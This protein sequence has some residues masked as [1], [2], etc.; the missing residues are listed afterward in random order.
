MLYIDKAQTEFYHSCITKA[1][2]AHDVY[3]KA[4]FYTLGLT[5]ETRRHI[6]TLYDFKNRCIITEGLFDGFQ[7]G[8]SIKVT[9]MAFNLFNGFTGD[10][11]ASEKDS[12][13]L[14]SPYN[15]YD[16]GLMAYF[17][18]A[19]KLRY[20]EYFHPHIKASHGS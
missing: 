16:T 15:L 11:Q 6:E 7:T 3:H 5:D 18:E 17:F 10:T 4:L 2:A 20:P 12:P 8:T 14:Y 1:S 19:V 9:R 13:S